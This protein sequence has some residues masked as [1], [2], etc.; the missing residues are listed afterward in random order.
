MPSKNDLVLGFSFIIFTICLSVILPSM[1]KVSLIG[2]FFLMMSLV[3]G[4]LWA[5]DVETKVNKLS[6]AYN[7][8]KEEH[9]CLCNKCQNK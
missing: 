2:T 1:F 7:R 6:V 9:V 4:I 5:S 8:I 3:F